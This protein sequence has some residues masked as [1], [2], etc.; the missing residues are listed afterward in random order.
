MARTTVKLDR[1]NQLDWLSDSPPTTPQKAKKE[2]DTGRVFI[3]PNREELFLGMTR[4]DQH[5]KHAGLLEPLH[6]AKLLDQL[7]WTEFE[8][9]YAKTG[10][11]PYAPQAMVGLILYGFMQGVHSLRGLERL[12]RQDVGCMWVTG[13]ICPD[14]ACLGR[15]VLLHEVSFSGELFESLTRQALTVTK[16]N[17]RTLAGDGSIVEAACSYYQLLR[18]DAVRERADEAKK[19]SLSDLNRRTG[20]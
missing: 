4:L 9:R 5:L 11:A 1:S 3:A 14:H 16:S 20:S 2:A 19:R 7:T 15:F 17:T 10:R 13:G 12:A 6:I 8:A 18:E